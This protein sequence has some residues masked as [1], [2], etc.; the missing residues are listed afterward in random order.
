MRKRIVFA[1]FLLSTC[2]V[3]WG[4]GFGQE[5]KKPLTK[6]EILRLLKPTPGTR[7]EQG[8]LAGEIAQRGIAF[9][10][11][12]KTLDE[13]RKAGARSFVIDAIQ[14]AAQN[15]APKQPQTQ[16]QP[17]SQTLPAAEAPTSGARPHLQSQS[18]PD[19]PSTTAEEASRDAPKIDVAKLPLLDQARYHAAEFMN[20]LPN[21][22]VTQIVTRSV[23]TPEKK[24][25]QQQD[26][27][28]IELS[29][30]TKTGEQFK[31]VRY[32]D[33]PTQMTYDQLNG[34][35]STGEF[36]SILG[37]LFSPQ[38]QAEFKEVRRETFHGHQTVIYDFRVKKAFSRN[39]ITDKNSGRTV[40]TAYSGSVWIDT[41]SGRALRIEQSSDDIQRGFPI[42]LAESAVEYDWITLDGQRHLLPVYAEIILGSDPERYYSRNVIELRNYHMFDTDLKILPEK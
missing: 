37:A 35:T 21:F 19:S 16:E 27:L 31:L 30:R 1:A 7:Y 28:E 8:D 38:S 2:C 22:V 23:R 42:T 41:E 40:T 12:E 24:D 29:Y 3:F 15:A 13:L 17:Q 5:A 34:A 4:N 33:K 32:N 11:D 36:G 14:K 26:K 18:S 39:T 25:W 20:D 6:Q 10:V 9:P